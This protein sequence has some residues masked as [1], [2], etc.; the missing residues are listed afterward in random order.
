M[1]GIAALEQPGSP[2]PAR[3]HDPGFIRSAT[4]ETFEA[5]EHEDSLAGGGNDHSARLR[6]QAQ[7]GAGGVGEQTKYLFRDS[8]PIPFGITVG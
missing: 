6:I 1:H 5:G 4:G 7:D 8:G 3:A 2:L